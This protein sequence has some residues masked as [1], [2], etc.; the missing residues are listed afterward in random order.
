MSCLELSISSG[1]SLSLAPLNTRKDLSPSRSVKTITMPVGKS[2][3][4]KIL[5][6]TLFDLRS[7]L[8]IFPGMSFPA[9]PMK[10]VL[11]PRSDIPTAI[12]PDPPG[13]SSA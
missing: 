5:V 12:F 2:S 4:K 10:A 11:S 8:Q 3:S 6:V 1:V 7:F 13:S 9:F